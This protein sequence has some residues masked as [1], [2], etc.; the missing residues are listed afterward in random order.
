M[1]TQMKLEEQIIAEIRSKI[2]DG[3]GHNYI[4]VYLSWKNLKLDGTFNM[5][6]L[7]IMADILKKYEND[8][9]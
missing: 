7:L 4:K 5:N 1:E 2:S 3:G 6:D 9:Q 8:M